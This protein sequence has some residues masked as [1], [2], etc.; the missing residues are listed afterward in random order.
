MKKQVSKIF[1]SLFISFIAL[2]SPALMAN[3]FFDDRIDYLSQLGKVLRCSQTSSANL[4]LI[5]LYEAKT[6]YY[7]QLEIPKGKNP[8]EGALAVVEKL[9]PIHATRHEYYKALLSHVLPT[10]I[11]FLQ[12]IQLGGRP[13]DSAI[14]PKDC[15][16]ETVLALRFFD[17]DNEMGF[18]F[19]ILIDQALYQ[20]LSYENQVASIIHALIAME[21]AMNDMIEAPVGT[22]MFTGLLLSSNIRLMNHKQFIDFLTQIDF[23]SW[24]D[25]FNP[26]REAM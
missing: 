19:E 17:A 20:E 10:K 15:Q 3:D 1:G 11:R 23:Y 5:D 7:F 22:R 2:N 4:Q 26:S 9:Q 21:G 14:I 18:D 25:F 13:T 6:Q 8:L 12:D 16:Q 24:L